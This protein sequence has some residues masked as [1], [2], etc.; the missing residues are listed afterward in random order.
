MRPPTGGLLAIR[1]E[2]RET[3]ANL[4]GPLKRRQRPRVLLAAARA[5]ADARLAVEHRFIKFEE[6]L[7]NVWHRHR[8]L[9]ELTRDGVRAA[10]LEVFAADGYESDTVTAF[11]PPPGATSQEVLRRLRE[12]FGVEAQGGQAHMADQLVRIGHMGWVHEPEMR[13]AVA[14]VAVIAE[15]LLAENAAPRPLRGASEPV[16]P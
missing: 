1:D 15:Q 16:T 3:I 10:G 8:R 14:A 11:R 6:A 12:Q 4:T 13:E 9:G 7:D 5:T 2:D